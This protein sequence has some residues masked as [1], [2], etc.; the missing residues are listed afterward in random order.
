MYRSGARRP[1]LAIAGGKGGAGKTTTTL[2]LA[3]AM[4]GPTLAVDADVDMPDL[5]AMAGV[6]RTPTLAAVAAD[7][8]GT[9]AAQPH[10]DHPDVAVVPALRNSEGGDGRGVGRR[11]AGGRNAD[12]GDAGGTDVAH[13]LSRLD[14]DAEA[15][16][17]VLVDCPAGA[18]RDAVAPLRAASGVL[19]VSTLCAPALRD[20]AKT[21]AMARELGTPVVGAAL[22]RARVRPDAVADLLDCPVLVAVPDAAPPV[23]D[24]RAVRAAYDRLAGHLFEGKLLRP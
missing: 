24:R 9:R 19:L 4:D 18:S 15:D 2:G 5:H 22:T 10:P 17:T 3:A 12:T 11:N 1:M 7:D 14:A 21:A 23:L 6:D 20:A 8:G 16:A 13:A